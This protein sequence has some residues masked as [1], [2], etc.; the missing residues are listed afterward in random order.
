[1][2]LAKK[3]RITTISLKNKQI[4]AILGHIWPV[5]GL[6]WPRYK[7]LMVLMS[8]FFLVLSGMSEIGKKISN[9]D[10]KVEKNANLTIFCLILACYGLGI[11]V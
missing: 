10:K 7:C 3:F 9:K 5:F 4:L 8:I 1:M 6:F 11:S 2:R